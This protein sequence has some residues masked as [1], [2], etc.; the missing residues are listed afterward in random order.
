MQAASA[1]DTVPTGEEDE[2]DV[3]E[4]EPVAVPAAATGGVSSVDSKS[5]LEDWYFK[6]DELDESAWA[7]DMGGPSSNH[8]ST[9]A[10][11]PEWF[12]FVN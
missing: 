9:D 6:G 12:P 1:T 7:A 8:T 3:D 11:L 2:E 5:T 10:R 4:D